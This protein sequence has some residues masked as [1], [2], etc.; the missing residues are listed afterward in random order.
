MHCVSSCVFEG[1]N[2]IFWQYSSKLD[3]NPISNGT[4][5]ILK[6]KNLYLSKC[7]YPVSVTPFLFCFVITE[8]LGLKSEK[9]ANVSTVIKGDDVR[10]TYRGVRIT[11]GLNHL[12][13]LCSQLIASCLLLKAW[14]VYWI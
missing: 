9:N 3:H 10:Q 5:M 8:T 4:S 1:F 14:V 12:F 6:N 13:N 7:L 11:I 2:C